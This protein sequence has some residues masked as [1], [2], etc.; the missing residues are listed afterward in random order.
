VALVIA[1]GFAGVLWQ[2]RR[3]ETNAAESRRKE[4]NARENLYAADIN[5]IQQALASDNLRQARELLQKQI[6]KPGEPDLRGFEWRYLWQQCQSE[7]LF[8]LPGHE[9]AVVSVQF[10]PDGRVLA[11][12]SHDNTIRIWDLNSRR[13]LATLTGHTNA[14][15]SISFSPHG[16]LLTSASD[17]MLQVWDAKTFQPL[18]T[19]PGGVREARF[20]P[21]GNYLVAAGADHRLIVYDTRFWNI[22]NSVE[23]PGLRSWGGDESATS[24]GLAFSP[25]SRLIAVVPEDG[26]N[27]LSLPDL[28]QLGTLKYPEG[29]MPGRR[30][31]SFSSDGRTLA[32]C[33]ADESHVKL[34]DRET[35]KELRSILVHT[36]SV[37]D[38][39]FSPDG[40]RLVTCSPDQTVKLWDAATGELVRTFKGHTA[41]VMCVAFSPD[42]KWLAS[43]SNDG[44]IKVWDTLAKSVQSPELPSNYW[45]TNQ[46]DNFL[47]FG[48]NLEGSLMVF[49]GMGTLTAYDPETLQKLSAQQVHDPLNKSGGATVVLG[50][51]FSDGRTGGWLI[52]EQTPGGKLDVFD[53]IRRQFLCSVENVAWR[54]AFAPRRQLLATATSNQTVT[55]WQLPAATRKFVLTN[56]IEPLAFSPDES[57]FASAD[58]RHATIKRWKFEGDIARPLPDLDAQTAYVDTMA[59]SPDGAILA[60]GVDEGS[61]KLWSVPSGRPVGTLTGH[62]R[63]DFSISFSPD[64]RTLASMADD[65]TVRLW[66]VA[67]Q[68][69]LLRF[70]L[71]MDRYAGN[72]IGFS[73]DGRSLMAERSMGFWNRLYYAPSFPEI[74]LT[75]GTFEKLAPPNDGM[76]WHVRG[77]ALDKWNRPEE[78]AKAFTEVIKRTAGRPEIE[79]LRTGALRHR[80]QV[81]KRLGRLTEAGADNCAA[82][83]IPS[84]DP[85]TPTRCVDLSPYFNGSLDRDF[86]DRNV[87]FYEP[88]PT[89]PRGCQ[90]L[91]GS[92]REMFDLR[93]VVQLRWEGGPAGLPRSVDTIAMQQKCRQL[94]FLHGT[95]RQESENREIG[96]YVVHYLDGTQEKIPILYG[97][98]LLDWWGE[99]ADLP[100]A[101]L[102]WKG[103]NSRAGPIRLFNRAWKNPRP[104]LEIQSLDFVSTMTQCAPFLIAITAEP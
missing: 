84:R 95:Y 29:R 60:A 45:N 12:A 81:L 90:P 9:R 68:R 73:P 48:F 43:A 25:D 52:D 34:W 53:L 76:S 7:E 50:N 30:F 104:E 71:P 19:L 26:I 69:E 6:P 49:N 63:S 4:L 37:Y 55:V 72:S 39:A 89:L 56:A 74:A 62:K 18:R 11:T 20:S 32:A 103:T 93:G 96:A 91:P 33:T 79:S 85:R 21:D 57:I 31:V 88:F 58:G 3:A 78:A 54:P 28:R 61:I 102:A 97:Q 23:I 15:Q 2:W 98:D 75:D 5:Q 87:P 36:D 94:Q 38:A 8:S 101:K 65:R 41:E 80:S 42:G 67:S 16:D 92:T 17:T 86:F 13:V 22:T 83:N 64:G 14:V 77:K 44:A 66:H 24:L 100:L 82:L 27:L 10:S 70:Q 51:L 46:I 35:Q 99:G 47:P 40:G 1:L 59:F